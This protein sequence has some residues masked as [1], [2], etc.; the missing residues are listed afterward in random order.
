MTDPIS[1]T[2]LALGVASLAI[3]VFEGV[4]RGYEYFEYAAN[5]PEDCASFKLRLRIEYSRIMDW[6]VVA[7]L[8][9]KKDYGRFNKKYTANRHIIMAVLSEMSALFRSLQKD[10]KELR[11]FENDELRLIGTS[12]G[13]TKDCVTKP[14]VGPQVRVTPADPEENGGQRRVKAIEKEAAD[15]IDVSVYGL[16][17]SPNVPKSQQKYTRGINHIMSFG[18]KAKSIATE[19][20]R[21]RWAF[22]DKTKY[23]EALQKLKDLT[24]YLHQTTGDYQ[25]ELLAQSTRETCLAMLRL[26]DSVQE[27]KALLEGAKV[28]KIP[29]PELE[30]DS[31]SVF[32]QATT[33]PNS[34][35]D[36]GPQGQGTLFERL[37]QFSIEHAEVFAAESGLG[38]RLDSADDFKIKLDAE[39]DRGS[40][41]SAVF[42]EQ[43]V[44]VEWKE[45]VPSPIQPKNEFDLPTWGPNPDLVKRLSQLS[46]LLEKRE[47]PEEFGIPNCLGFFQ[48]K[49]P[50][51]RFGFILEMPKRSQRKAVPKSLF[52]ILTNEQSKSTINERIEIAQGVVTS[53][54]CLHAVGWLHKGLRSASIL[55]SDT[56]SEGSIGKPFISGFEYARPFALNMTSTRP[57]NDLMWAI[58]CHPDYQGNAPGPYCK[59]FDIYSLG[60]ILLEIAYWK[61]ADELFQ[62]TEEVKGAEARALV[63]AEAQVTLTKDKA[64][65]QAAQEAEVFKSGLLKRTR[66]RIL[67]DDSGLMSYVKHT[68]GKRYYNA[69]IACIQGVDIS[70]FGPEAGDTE[71]VVDAVMQQAFL[72]QV[73]DELQGIRL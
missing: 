43:Q 21:L 55:F 56:S 41:T 48:D 51:N 63:K 31:G 28:V 40:R 17:Q 72:R 6:A 70:Q 58:Y 39:T 67:N 20:K 23:F 47:K 13:A 53:L 5:M 24:D 32:S 22:V 11:W 49:P 18:K 26:T 50:R 30:I 4:K 62:I 44:W 15:S 45:F 61:T 52:E 69:V 64:K 57:P 12:H 2:S 14:D 3:E 46:A 9:D 36:C 1:I 66:D 10:Y 33:L 27:M 19:P 37:A 34:S 60:I 68:M 59:V 35:E 7:G 8:A 54:F 42:R 16:F 71:L 29:D 25:L 65:K 73:I 38:T